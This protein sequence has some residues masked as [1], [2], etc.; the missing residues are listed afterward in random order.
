MLKLRDVL[1]R[2]E[3]DALSQLEAA[4][5]LGISERT[6]RCRATRQTDPLTT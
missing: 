2:R 5:R 3:A 1:S 4:E 6:L